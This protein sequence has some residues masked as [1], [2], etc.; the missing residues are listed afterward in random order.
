MLR[1]YDSIQPKFVLEVTSN[2]SRNLRVDV[3]R[4]PGLPGFVGPEN[5]IIRLISNYGRKQWNEICNAFHASEVLSK[6]I[7]RAHKMKPVLKEIN[8]C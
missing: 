2:K 7:M 5:T 8:K 3:G 1:E 4:P 6:V